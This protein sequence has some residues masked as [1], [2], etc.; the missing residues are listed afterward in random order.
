MFSPP[1]EDEDAPFHVQSDHEPPKQLTG[2]GV[3]GVIKRPPLMH[4]KSDTHISRCGTN[5]AFRR[6]SPP[7]IIASGTPVQSEKP[8]TTPKGSSDAVIVPGQ[9]RKHISFNTFVEQCIAIEKPKKKRMMWNVEYLN[10]KTL[11]SSGN[12]EG[13]G[14]EDDGSVSGCSFIE[15][16]LFL[17][18]SSFCPHRYDEDSEDGIIIDEADELLFGDEDD[19]PNPQSHPQASPPQNTPSHPHTSPPQN[20]SPLS[21]ST[22]EEEDEDEVLEMRV[23]H[24]SN[25]PPSPTRSSSHSSSSTSSSSS[26]SRPPKARTASYSHRSNIN[27]SSLH[28]RQP[29]A[30]ALMRTCS[31]DKELVTI[32]LIAPTILKTRAEEDEHYPYVHSHSYPHPS[33]SD[34]WYSYGAQDSPV[35]L[36]YVPP[37]YICADNRDADADRARD[38]DVDPYERSLQPGRF[39]DHP[40]VASPSP[41]EDPPIKD[42]RTYFGQRNRAEPESGRSPGALRDVAKSVPVACNSG[43]PEVVISSEDTPVERMSRSRSRSRSRS[44]SLSRSRTPSPASSGPLPTP[45]T[46]VPVPRNSSS[47]PSA[48][49]DL[50]QLPDA[51]TSRGRSVSSPTL[52]SQ[53]DMPQMR[54]RS[55]T[56]TSSYSDRNSGSADSPIGSLSPDGAFGLGIGIGSVYAGGRDRDGR[57]DRE[58]EGVGRLGERGRDRVGR[59]A[60]S[61]SSLSPEQQQPSAVVTVSSADPE[62]KKKRTSVSSSSGSS[63]ISAASVTTTRPSCLVVDTEPDRRTDLTGATS[64]CSS[65]TVRAMSPNEA[66]TINEE[67]ERI[68]RQPTPANSPVLA[69]R[70]A[71]PLPKPSSTTSSLKHER[72][73][74]AGM[75]RSPTRGDDRQSDTLVGRAV[76]IMSN[77]GAFI[78]SFWHTGTQTSVV[79]P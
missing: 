32:A 66:Q 23:R 10:S 72:K 45:S 67:Q 76:E 17:V 61:G 53:T 50:L 20:A 33:T 74:S 25:V 42:T 55:I 4:T 29:S 5:G 22:S 28:N 35:E 52:S 44:K 27:N 51:G 24:P 7:R 64:A 75:S 71:L 77:A 79:A 13:Y 21:S 60:G 59:R 68:S 41:E 73:P 16:H 3:A 6:D 43:G 8:L 65:S 70:Y 48:S 39:F 14:A 58:R 1:D 15:V 26:R 62:P 54:G 40:L 56:R 31:T 69:M 38:V 63:T 47:H 37:S 57:G 46:A 49:S 12:C 9:K 2:P 19:H 11:D 36:V 18:Y 78:G 30:S 34:K